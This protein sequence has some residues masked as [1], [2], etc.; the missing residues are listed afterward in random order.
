MI[1]L[2]KTPDVFSYSLTDD[3][4]CNVLREVAQELRVED[5]VGAMSA[6]CALLFRVL[7]LDE[8]TLRALRGLFTGVLSASCIAT[9]YALLDNDCADER[10]RVLRSLLLEL[11]PPDALSLL[12]LHYVRSNPLARVD[13]GLLETIYLQSRDAVAS[14][15]TL[16]WCQNVIARRFQ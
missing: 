5:Q 10:L 14:A 2:L 12:L 4:T 15:L 8:T 13:A 9:L 3:H 6:E 1:A 11:L 16:E 7:D